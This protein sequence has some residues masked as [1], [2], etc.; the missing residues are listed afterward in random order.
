MRAIFAR[1]SL[2]DTLN[3]PGYF[4]GYLS[5]FPGTKTPI[6][7]RKRNV[8]RKSPGIYRKSQYVT[9]SCFPLER[10]ISIYSRSQQT[11]LKKCVKYFLDLCYEIMII[12]E[13]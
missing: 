2:Q 13:R 4:P 11:G 5:G 8:T 3:S 9:K 10:H 6:A 1:L 12:N 7:H